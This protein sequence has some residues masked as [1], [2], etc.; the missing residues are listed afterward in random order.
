MVAIFL[1]DL[2]LLLRD[3]S[4]LVLSLL[5]PIAMITI[6]TFGR[7]ESEPPRPLVPVVD[8]DEGPVAGAFVEL[9][10]RHA[11]VAVMDQA[12]AERVV[13][14]LNRAPAAII[15]PEGL[16][17]RYLQGQ[18]STITM[19]TDPAQGVALDDVRALLLVMDRDAAELADPLHEELLVY[20]DRNVTG[21]D[22]AS[23]SREQNVPGFALMFVL[24]AVVFGTSSAMHD[25]R[26]WGT[27]PRLLLAPARFTRLFVGKLGVRVVLG[28]VQ[29]LVLLLWGRLVFGI[30]LGPSIPALLLLTA[31]IAFATAALGLLI[32]AVAATRE[33]TLP[34]SLAA[35]LGLSALCGL[36][37]P[38]SFVPAWLRNLGQLFFPTWAMYGMTDLILRERGLGATLLPVGVTVMQGAA[39]LAIGLWIFRARYMPR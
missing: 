16:S 28:F 4:A 9:L 32:G 38:L 18:P 35:T 3:A 21:R 27:L 30:S 20:Q 11:N 39:L 1:K 37:W 31:A 10:G 7:Y 26:S 25:E 2:R 15:F 19:L 12:G 36:W 14:D 29:L 33:Q 17:K 34:L 8:Y 23:K 24:L 22:R 6:I 13:R 5:A